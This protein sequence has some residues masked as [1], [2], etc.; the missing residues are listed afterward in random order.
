[1]TA[2]YLLRFPLDCNIHNGSATI[3]PFYFVKH[4]S[5]VLFS[6]A[7]FQKDLFG[8][9]SGGADLKAWLIACV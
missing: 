4:I 9:G 2:T 8:L 7:I 3:D 6:F 1:V 5:R